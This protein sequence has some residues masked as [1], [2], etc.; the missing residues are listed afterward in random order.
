MNEKYL[1]ELERNLEIQASGFLMKKDSLLLQSQ[2]RTEQFQISLLDRLRSMLNSQVAIDISQ[3]G[4]SQGILREVASDHICLET[5]HKEIV[6]QANCIDYIINL[7]KHS[8]PPTMMQSKW[9]LQSFLRSALIERHQ[10]L[11]CLSK[12]NLISGQ[13]VSV[14]LDH[15]DVLNHQFQYA[16][17]FSKVI[18]ISR[19]RDSDD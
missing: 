12:K 2:I 8:K 4:I 15:F 6:I 16:I 5:E 11:V 18:Y 9:N 3:I 14:F 10:I 17:P 7:N 1:F 19:D 13:I